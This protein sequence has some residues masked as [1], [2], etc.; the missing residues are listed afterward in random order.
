MMDDRNQ[1]V[2]LLLSFDQD[3][4]DRLDSPDSSA[5]KSIFHFRN[6]DVIQSILETGQVR[7]YDA[8]NQED[9]DEIWLGIKCLLDRIP[10]DLLT[11]CGLVRGALWNHLGAYRQ[12]YE[13]EI[14]SSGR[15]LRLFILC[16]RTDNKPGARLKYG[17]N[18]LELRLN[19]LF[20]EHVPV[21]GENRALYFKGARVLYG[22]GIELLSALFN[23]LVQFH[24]PS[25]RALSLSARYFSITHLLEFAAVWWKNAKYSEE[26]EYRIV[27]QQVDDNVIRRD[28]SREF[29]CLK[30]QPDYIGSVFV[31]SPQLRSGLASQSLFPWLVD[32]VIG[33]DDRA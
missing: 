16:A 13:T 24:A 9:Q 12:N 11:L 8:R 3:F 14:R 10:E 31:K 21:D 28:D 5:S 30:L 25:L 20:R 18:Y 1:F 17:D 27:V 29:L 32:K 4:V 26:H 7:V 33:L 22:Q 15:G 6:D 2:E 23:D 19:A